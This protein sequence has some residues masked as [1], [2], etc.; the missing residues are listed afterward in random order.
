MAPTPN[1][2]LRETTFADY[3]QV[4]ALESG[5]NLRRRSREEWSRLW[6]ENPLYK[7]LGSSWPIGWVLE[8]EGRI[9]G[10]IGNIPLAYVYQGRKLI[11]AG[12]RAW[13]VDERYRSMA[14][15]LMDTYFNQQGV[16][17]Y[18][19]TTV[20]A[21]AAE[22]FGVFGSSP[23]P[24]GDW[25]AASYWVTG[26][27]G[28]AKTALTVKKLPHP[29]LLCY[30]AAACL[31]L[32]DQVTSK[33]LPAVSRDIEV[34]RSNRFDERFDTF[35]NKLAS[36]RRILMGVRDREALDWHFGVP[37]QRGDVWLFTIPITGSLAAYAIFQ[38]RDEPRSG[39]KRMRLVDFQ[40]LSR[41][42]DCLRA[43]LAEALK[44][45]QRD[46]IHVLEKVGLKVEDTSLID[47][48]AP[49]RRKLPAW[50]FFFYAPDPEFQQT[51]QSPSAWL[52]SSFDGDSSL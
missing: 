16:D 35:W 37:L 41:E 32:K 38:R 46:G 6:L 22:A 8:D 1:V 23:V 20:N 50:P 31:Y 25:S 2:D 43:I 5:Q 18:L 10:T 33:R 13:A 24:A 9:V 39:L 19:N 34:Q 27:P 49:Y 40:A 12:G 7:Q 3:D 30:P 42:S 28:F 51:L 47:E 48:Y 11:V 4:I 36:E 15:M 44:L 17:L 29:Q 21:L 45:C 26:Y 52:P 14:L